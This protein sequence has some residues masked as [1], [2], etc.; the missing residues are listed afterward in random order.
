MK[1]N[2]KKI[3]I[4]IAG[5]MVLTLIVVIGSYWINSIL[6]V[7]TED[8]RITG[9]M[10]KISPQG[11]GKIVD[12]FIE[13]GSYVEK[14]EIVGRLEIINLNDPNIELSLIRSPISGIVIK[15]QGTVGEIISAGQILAY[16]IDPDALYVSANIE[17]TK[18]KKIKT[19]QK[20]VIKLDEYKGK[21]F[22]GKVRS[23]GEA[24][25]S[26]FSLLSLSSESTFTK[27]VQKIPVNIDLDYKGV[28]LSA[29]TN[30]FVKIHIK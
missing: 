20:V 3:I 6:Y 9:D 25:N 18:L 13:E 26:I 1:V 4:L 10:V 24:A 21:K 16:A 7:S 12:L 23:V 5:L 11:S 27:V 2:R 29:G 22:F 17:E 14:N 19:G 15:K 8:A 28:K 30:A